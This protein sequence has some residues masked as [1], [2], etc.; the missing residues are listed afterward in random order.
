MQAVRTEDADGRRFEIVLDDGFVW[1]L[2]AE[3]FEAMITWMDE[4]RV[5]KAE[6]QASGFQPSTSRFAS[7]DTV[8]VSDLSIEEADE[9]Q[10][11][12]PTRP[13]EGL[14]LSHRQEVSSEG[15]KRVRVF[16]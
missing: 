11:G 1:Q 13:V 12:Q 10:A 4:L 9:Q 7:G 6:L 2:M 3:D 16:R 5:R 8:T 15:R 14:A